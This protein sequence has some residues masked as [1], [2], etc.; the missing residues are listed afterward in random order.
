MNTQT[1]TDRIVKETVL[2]APLSRVWRA[3]SDAAEFGEWFKVDMSGQTFRPG[4][5]VH[6]KM[7]YPGHEGTP[8]EIVVARVEPE[9]LFSFRWHP[10]G[11]GPDFDHPDDPMTLIEFELEEVEGGTKLTVTESG[12]DNIPLAR[13][14]E[15]FRGNDEGWAMQ[16]TNIEAYVTS[17]SS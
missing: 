6:A 3:I 16:L 10:W 17:R 12:F 13:R 5:P 1:T 7:T 8:F 2:K 15:A 4:E 11:V 9:R 14:G